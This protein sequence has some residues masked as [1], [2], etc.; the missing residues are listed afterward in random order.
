MIKHIRKWI[1]EP[2][3]RLIL[4]GTII[5]MAPALRNGFPFTYADT[6]S[7]LHAG[8][9][10]SVPFDRPIFY[11]LW[12][13]ITSL[14]FSLWLPVV[15][16]TA[17]TS[18]FVLR[19][20]KLF[21]P[22]EKLAVVF[23][24]GLVVLTLFSGMALNAAMLLPDAFT[25]ILVL[26]FLLYLTT[27]THNKQYLAWMLIAASMHN[28]HWLML[29]ALGVVAW[30]IRKNGSFEV[31]K[32]R[33]VMG[34]TLLAV[35]MLSVTNWLKFREFKPSVATHFFMMGRLAETGVLCE[36]LNK[37]CEQD[38]DYFLCDVKAQFP[39]GA[40]EYIWSEIGPT[41]YK[42]GLEV[43]TED[44]K[45][46]VW[47][48]LSSP[49]PAMIFAYRSATD[50]VHQLFLNR[51]SL[52]RHGLEGRTHL[53]MEKHF[54]TDATAVRQSM[55]AYENGLKDWMHL[56]Y[57]V[58]LMLSL[59]ILGLA[60]YRNLLG[61][62]AK[63]LLAAV[64]LNALITATFANVDTRLQARVAWLAIVAAAY[65]YFKHRSLLWS[66]SR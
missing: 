31:V 47:D 5:I 43:H 46:L 18:L 20:V 12:L 10:V 38:A 61:S 60:W 62:E 45:Q 57:Q 63:V 4:V 15:A 29:G 7:Y 34:I 52:E 22:K 21:V 37:R 23:I 24:G 58:L 14:T 53:K 32:L 28:S 66:E 13:A 39:M 26:S 27:T 55:Q 40:S 35:T 64:C 11:G 25:P 30:L 56:G 9:T 42:G 49:K 59:A 6:H 36:Y 54:P 16:Q 3:F 48:V 8:M 17:L 41:R 33:K 44:Y 1:S 65:I 50:A 51:I 19:T 2:D